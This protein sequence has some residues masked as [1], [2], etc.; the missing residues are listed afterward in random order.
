MLD[1]AVILQHSRVEL[2]LTPEP[3]IRTTE[4][5]ILTPRATLHSTLVAALGEEVVEGSF[6]AA[7]RDARIE[8]AL[9]VLLQ[10]CLDRVPVYS[11]A[12][13]QPQRAWHGFGVLADVLP[14]ACGVMEIAG[15]K[16]VGKSVSAAD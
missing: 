1:F 10:H 12:D 9:D 16:G 6:G 14:W 8:A 2:Q 7:R 13:I 11:G 15:G 5:V 3:N 4:A